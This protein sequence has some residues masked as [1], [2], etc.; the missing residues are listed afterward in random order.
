MS[1]LGLK[2]I[3]MRRGC[4]N[5][6][7]HFVFITGCNIFV[8][9]DPQLHKY[10]VLRYRKALRL[11]R[12]GLSAKNSVPPPDDDYDDDNINNN[13]K[14]INNNNTVDN[15]SAIGGRHSHCGGNSV[16]Y[17]YIAAS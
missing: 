17:P 10:W 3:S 8:A 9:H 4:L 14:D 12:H 13:N 15:N 11:S 7:T 1:I 16:S 2:P 6:Q 5:V